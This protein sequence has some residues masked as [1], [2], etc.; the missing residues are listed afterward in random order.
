MVLLEDALCT[1]IRVD[2]V[3]E[4]SSVLLTFQDDINSGSEI[5]ELAFV[6]QMAQNWKNSGIGKF[7]S[8]GKIY[9]HWR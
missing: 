4:L 8:V 3:Y 5:S 7:T 1:L 2:N 9:N 6:D